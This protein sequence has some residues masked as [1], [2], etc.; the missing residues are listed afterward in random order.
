MHFAL[1]N[2]NQDTFCA[3]SRRKDGNDEL[4]ELPGTKY[5]VK[6]HLQANNY[7]ESDFECIVEKKNGMLS[8]QNAKKIKIKPAT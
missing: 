4:F 5:K 6:I 1:D 3:Y 8:V 7:A 2:P